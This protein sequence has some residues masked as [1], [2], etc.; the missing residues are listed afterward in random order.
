MNFLHDC[1]Q[2]KHK[3]I[4]A[5]NIV[6]LVVGA[7]NQV[8]G[9]NDTAT[10]SNDTATD[11]NDTAMGSND[12]AMGSNDTASGSCDPSQLLASYLF[13]EMLY[14]F[15]YFGTYLINPPP[16]SRKNDKTPKIQNK[17]QLNPKEPSPVGLKSWFWQTLFGSNS[18]QSLETCWLRP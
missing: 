2:N 17:T 9:N 3:P 11:S 1:F 16:S 15:I 6:F 7:D 13:R 4:Q 14:H 10:G 5:R 12:T 18:R 8:P